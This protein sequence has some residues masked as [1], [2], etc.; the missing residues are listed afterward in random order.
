MGASQWKT[1]RRWVHDRSGLDKCHKATA[2]V[3]A[4]PAEVDL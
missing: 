1:R 4:P 2:R 3:E